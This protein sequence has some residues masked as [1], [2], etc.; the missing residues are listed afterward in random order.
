MGGDFNQSP[1]HLKAEF[2]GQPFDFVDFHVIPDTLLP[3]DWQYVFDN[4]TPSNRR[5]DMPYKKGETKVT[6]IDF[7]IVSPNVLVELVKCD[8]LE[9]EFSDHNPVRAVFRLME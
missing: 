8:E 7:F 2:E 3:A 9:F 6:L 5:V 1:L 4:A